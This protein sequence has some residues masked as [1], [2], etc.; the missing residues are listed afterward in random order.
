MVSGSTQSAP[1]LYRECSPMKKKG[2]KAKDGNT[3][4][5][6]PKEKKKK[7]AEGYRL[8]DQPDMIDN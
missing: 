7:K 8:K 2:K 6:R 1:S 4:V 5:A 3:Y